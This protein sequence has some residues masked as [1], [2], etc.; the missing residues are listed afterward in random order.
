MYAYFVFAYQG[1]SSQHWEPTYQFYHTF[2]GILPH[3]KH[4]EFLQQKY[5]AKIVSLANKHTKIHSVITKISALKG[6][7]D[8]FS[9]LKTHYARIEA[10]SH[11][12]YFP[13]C[14]IPRQLNALTL[15]SKILI[16]YSTKIFSCSFTFYDSEKK[17]QTRFSIQL[18]HLRCWN[19]HQ[20]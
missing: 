7:K 2:Q 14:I 17:R 12:S 4:M 1:N 20:N 3:P 13:G 16:F 5:E 11:L 15:A 10:P 19:S 18:L 6:K 8:L 9:L